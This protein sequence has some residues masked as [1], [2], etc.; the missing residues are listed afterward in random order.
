MNMVWHNNVF[1]NF[2]NIPDV[3]FYNIT[4]GGWDDVGIVPYDMT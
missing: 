2:G 4:I 3:F 1:F